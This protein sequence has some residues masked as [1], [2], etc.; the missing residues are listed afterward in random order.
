MEQGVLKM[1][2]QE[3]I[4]VFHAV[5]SVLRAFRQNSGGLGWE[6]SPEQAAEWRNAYARG[7]TGL[8]ELHKQVCGILQSS[9][10]PELYPQG[11]KLDNEVVSEGFAVDIVLAPKAGSL[12]LRIEVDGPTHFV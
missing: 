6:P 1:R 8:S 5:F 7:D 4:S 3:R 11:C 9:V 2:G 10:L 12:R